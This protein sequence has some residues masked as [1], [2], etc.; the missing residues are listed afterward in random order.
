MRSTTGNVSSSPTS[1]PTPSGSGSGALRLSPDFKRAYLEKW[2][3]LIPAVPNSAASLRRQNNLSIGAVMSRLPAPTVAGAGDSSKHGSVHRKELSYTSTDGTELILHRFKPLRMP[4]G[5][6]SSSNDNSSDDGSGN[7]TIAQ[8]SE[9]NNNND[10]D[11]DEDK[12]GDEDAEPAVSHPAVLYLHG[13]GFLSGSVELFAPDI[14]RYAAATGLT[15]YAPAYRLAPEAPFPKPLEDVYAALEWLHGH[16]GAEGIDRRR[17]AVMGHSAGGNL[18]AAAALLARDR[19]LSPGIER[20]VLVYPMLDD[21]TQIAG[22]SP[23]AE[24]LT[25]Y[26]GAPA[27]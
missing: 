26:V 17:I 23:L 19:G 12:N 13:G 22:D 18:G 1:P 5:R 9:D 11:E 21:R 15:L 6:G 14:A 10:G 3:N 20:L 24:F 7:S 4:G 2:G 8:H 27:S 16:A 25:W